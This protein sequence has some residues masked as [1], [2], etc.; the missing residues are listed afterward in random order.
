[1][2]RAATERRNASGLEVYVQAV[3]LKKEKNGLAKLPHMHDAVQRCNHMLW[4]DDILGGYI[5]VLVLSLCGSCS[6][7]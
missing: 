5:P 1:M 3:V 2:M 6:P 7:C 4:N